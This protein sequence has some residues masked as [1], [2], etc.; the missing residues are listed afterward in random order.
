MGATRGAR[1]VLNTAPY[2]AL[3]GE[4]LALADPVVANEAEAAALAAAGE[5]PVQLLV[6]RGAAGSQWGELRVP[7]D[8]VAAPVDT[9]GAG[10][11]Y[12]GA[13][14]AAFAAGAGPAD[15]MRAAAAAAARSVTWLGAQPDPPAGR[16][17]A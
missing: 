4:V 6:T 7:A 11:T 5:Q 9:T 2:A 14:A 16:I 10:D 17:E 12:C 15:A 13:L 1:V 3:P 8:A